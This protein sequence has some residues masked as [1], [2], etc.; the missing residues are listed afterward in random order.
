MSFVNKWG[1]L[2]LRY[3]QDFIYKMLPNLVESVNR[4]AKAL[5]ENNELRKAELGIKEDKECENKD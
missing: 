5:E 4:L 1:V 2:M 3:E